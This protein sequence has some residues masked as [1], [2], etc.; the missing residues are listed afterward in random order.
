MTPLTLVSNQEIIFQPESLL[1]KRGEYSGGNDT[2][3]TAREV[4]NVI[5]RGPGATIRMWS[6][7]YANPD[8]YTSAEWRHC[9]QLRG[10][11][12]VE[13]HGLTLAESGGDGIYLGIGSEG[14]TNLNITIRDVVCDDNYRQG[15]R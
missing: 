10:A 14:E 6:E 8:L 4:E 11:T 9:P 13:V 5:L 12:N 15:S 1:A 2:V 3:L 7:D